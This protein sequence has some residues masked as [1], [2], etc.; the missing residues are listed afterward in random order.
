MN[1]IRGKEIAM[2]FQD[3]MASLNPVL[4]IGFQ[5]ME[6]M[7]HH[8]SF[9]KKQAKERTIALLEEVGIPDGEAQLY[10]YTHQFFGGMSQR[11]TIAMAI[12]CN[13]KLLIAD[14]PTTA[15]DVTIQAQIIDMM[16]DLQTCRD[17]AIIWISHDLGSFQK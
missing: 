5:L 14:E 10:R 4:T 11:I 2:I 3:P 16:K 9:N 12:S 1:K 17:M 8:L 7:M 15:L 6:T 13:P